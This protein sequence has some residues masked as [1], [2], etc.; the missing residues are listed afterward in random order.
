MAGKETPKSKPEHDPKKKRAFRTH[1][2]FELLKVIL[3]ESPPLRQRVLRMIE[4]H[5]GKQRLAASKP[6]AKNPA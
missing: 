2:D 5:L 3:D 1:D 6:P 4:K